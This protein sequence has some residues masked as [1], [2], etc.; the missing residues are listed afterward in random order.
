MGGKALLGKSG[1]QALHGAPRTASGSGNLSR[2]DWQ[3]SQHPAATAGSRKFRLQAPAGSPVPRWQ[4]PTPGSALNPRLCVAG[5]GTP[6]LG[7]QAPGPLL[8]PDSPPGGH[9]PKNRTRLRRCQLLN[10]G[11]PDIWILSEFLEQFN[12]E[13]LNSES[14]GGKALLGKSGSQALHGAPRTA[15]G[16]GNLSRLDWQASQHPAATAGSRKF[17]LQAPAGSP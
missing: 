13:R 11:T 17:R 8:P 2:L 9:T 14:M 3:A 5:T 6:D 1:S 7:D 16:S 15:S 4:G 10:I 12:L